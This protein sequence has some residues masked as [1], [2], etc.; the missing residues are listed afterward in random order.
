MSFEFIAGLFIFS[1]KC[2]E[3]CI[4]EFVFPVTGPMIFT[5]NFARGCVEELIAETIGLSGLYLR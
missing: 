2:V 5:R 1:I 3:F 4:Y